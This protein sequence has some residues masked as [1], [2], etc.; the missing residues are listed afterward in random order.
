MRATPRVTRSVNADVK[1]DMAEGIASAEPRSRA[2][3][4][5][6]GNTNARQLKLT[7][8]LNGSD[9]NQANNVLHKSSANAE[10]ANDKETC[11][12]NGFRMINVGD[13]TTLVQ[14]RK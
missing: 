4:R 11:D 9:D 14:H 7:K 10:H 5:S 1:M 3:G 6:D 12:E 13:V 2:Y 8:T